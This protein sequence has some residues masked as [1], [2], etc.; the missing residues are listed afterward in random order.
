MRLN[1]RKSRKYHML[2]YSC[3]LQTGK[4]YERVHRSLWKGCK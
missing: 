1:R 4:S 3:K 2:W